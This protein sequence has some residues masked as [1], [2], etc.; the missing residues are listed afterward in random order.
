MFSSCKQIDELPL[1]TKAS[2]LAVADSGGD[3]SSVC[4]DDVATTFAGDC[5]LLPSISCATCASVS[6]L[7]GSWRKAVGGYDLR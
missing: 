3:A 4:G 2:D 7:A 1:V 6:P 5:K